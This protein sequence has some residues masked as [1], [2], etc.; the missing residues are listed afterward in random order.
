M[1]VARPGVKSRLLNVR[2]PCGEFCVGATRLSHG[3][4]RGQERLE[5]SSFGYSPT[6]FPLLFCPPLASI[7]RTAESC[8]C[9]LEV[10]F[11]AVVVFGVM[12]HHAST[13]RRSPSP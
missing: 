1:S 2:T 10:L 5:H 8:D 3:E 12:L 7:T 6:S 11:R 4:N 9:E 13:R